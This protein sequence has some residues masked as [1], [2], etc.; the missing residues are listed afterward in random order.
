MPTNNFQLYAIFLILF[1]LP[2][3]YKSESVFVDNGWI[4]F[5]EL[6]SK[7]ASL[8]AKPNVIAQED[9]R[10]FGFTHKLKHYE[11][12]SWS[13]YTGYVFNSV[14]F[15]ISGKT[16]GYFG[17]GDGMTQSHFLALG[18]QKEIAD[19]WPRLS[20]SP[21]I[22]LKG[23]YVTQTSWD[24]IKGS[25]LNDYRSAGIYGT[26]RYKGYPGIKPPLLEL[27]LPLDIRVWK[28]LIV[29]FKVGAALG[30]SPIQDISY[31][32]RQH[33]GPE[34]YVRQYINGTSTTSTIGL[35]YKFK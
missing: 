12:W 5:N 32:W 10:T 11:G 21:G 23:L 9:Y 16:S 8:L 14:E 28:G 22:Y 27:Q 7:P 15:A 17:Q 30:F 33:N 29:S 4:F 3:G 31:T 20:V 34:Q 2:F 1:V 35:K 18:I 25:P 13:I 6:Q 19:R 26:L 24:N